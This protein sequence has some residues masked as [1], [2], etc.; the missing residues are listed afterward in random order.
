MVAQARKAFR[1]RLVEIA[2]V[3]GG[4]FS[5]RQALEA[6]YSYPAQHYHALHQNWLRVG[7]GIFRLPEWPSGPHEDLVRW[8]LWSGRRAVVS[9]ES[10][11]AVHDLG[12]V[13][14]TQA[15]LCVPPGFRGKAAG[16]VLHHAEVAPSEKQEHPGFWVT[17]PPRSLIDVA[18]GSLDV[19]QIVTAIRD[20]LA[21]GLVTARRL[22]AR[23]DVAGERS[24]L[25]IERALAM[26]EGRPSSVPETREAGRPRALGRR[27]R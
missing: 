12:D 21:R 4:Y 19:D 8:T 14:P 9:H 3:Q 11:L 2:S 22:R 18:A 1:K 13:N 6:G 23:A 7:R 24:A 15:H 25:R 17:T 27:R 10:A 26:I 16:V 20:A 5:A